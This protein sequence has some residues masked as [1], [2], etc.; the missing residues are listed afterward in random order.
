MVNCSVVAQI[1]S[2]SQMI[3]ATD[4]NGNHDS[5]YAPSNIDDNIIVGTNTPTG[6]LKHISGGTT[7]TG[8]DDVNNITTGS[9]CVTSS[10]STT[11]SIGTKN[12]ISKGGGGVVSGIVG[13]VNAG[14]ITD[15]LKRS[16]LNKRNGVDGSPKK[17]PLRY[18]TYFVYFNL[19]LSLY[20][21][22]NK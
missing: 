8:D 12:T 9:C 14:G 5:G 21:S 22:T 11:T 15:S 18:L 19:F 20:A 17:E 6:S 1:A 2:P 16:S 10:S 7:T 3:T 13:T 4:P